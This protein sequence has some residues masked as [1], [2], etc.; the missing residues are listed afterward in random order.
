MDEIAVGRS[1]VL[2]A[3]G[4]L[5]VLVCAG[6]CAPAQQP[7]ESP[8]HWDGCDEIREH[9]DPETANLRFSDPH[10]ESSGEQS[11]WPLRVGDLS[12]EIPRQEYEL[13][14]SVDDPTGVNVILLAEE[15]Q[16]VITGWV[17]S[18]IEDIWMKTAFGPS[19]EGQERAQEESSEERRAAT[20]ELFDGYPTIHDLSLIAYQHT[21]EDL[22]CLS[23]RERQ[24]VPIAIA[25][26]LNSLPVHSVHY[27]QF[28]LNE[29]AYVRS[30]EDDETW[31]WSVRVPMEEV[32]REVV[33]RAPDPEA[34]RQL[35]A[36]ARITRAGD[37]PIPEDAP[38]WLALLAAAS[39][40]PG[41]PQV[42]RAL[43][44]WLEEEGASERSRNS[45]RQIGE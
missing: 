29:I 34:L 7:S 2:F 37:E 28:G 39:Q 22:S 23:E 42:W 19:N 12:V 13:L 5:G 40:D 16:L 14:V 8:T 38:G 26:M 43:E 1:R 18:P 45:V 30:S 36:V 35:A 3:M 4:L 10:L 6:S 20:R 15:F 32:T 24:E 11:T 17:D 31:S 9:L 27:D 44:E 21:L 25:L 33:L 41:E